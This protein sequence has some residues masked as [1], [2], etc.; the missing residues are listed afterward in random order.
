MPQPRHALVLTAGLGTRLHPLTMVRAKPAI[1]VAGTPM[2]ARIIAGLAAGGV[3]DIVL[4]LHHLP[5]TLTSIVGDGS[6]LGVRVRYTWEPVILGSAGGPRRALQVLGADTFFIVNGDTL[7][8]VDLRSLAA[9][10]E[11]SGALVTMALTPNHQPER[12]GGVKLDGRNAVVGFPKKGSPA[13]SYHFVGVQVAHAEAFLPLEEGRPLNTVGAVYDELIGRCPGAIV[14][15]VS[16]ADFWDVGTP[17][18]YLRTSLAFAA[19]ESGGN[20][21]PG[22]G[23]RIDPAADIGGSIV[24]D[25][26]TI[27]PGCKLR[28]C[29][30]ADGVQVPHDAAY[31]KQI[32][33]CDGNGGISASSYE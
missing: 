9:S 26:V 7:T 13:Q 16:E 8:T 30:V 4:N 17:G 1:P 10:H 3:T 5:H 22:L 23:S 28:D 27:G 24:W 20:L 15:S 11:S 6:D 18:D 25:D 29:I 31:S 12:Y 2:I 21:R 33:V 32:L 14:G 19:A